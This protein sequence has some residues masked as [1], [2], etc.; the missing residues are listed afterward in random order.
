MCLRVI[1]HLMPAAHDLA[2]ELRMLLR[3]ITDEEEDRL[4]AMVV[5]DVEDSRCVLRVRTIINR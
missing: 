5:E 4:Q 1:R 2:H 3:T